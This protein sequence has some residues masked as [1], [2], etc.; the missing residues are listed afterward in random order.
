MPAERVNSARPFYHAGVDFCGPIKTHYKVRGKTPTKSY[1]AIF[2]CFS[3]KAIHI[4]VVGDLSSQSFIYALKRF[5]GKR[6]LCHTIF[7]DN[8]TNF[9]GAKNEL[10]ELAKIFNSSRIQAAIHTYC[11]EE[12]ITWKNI[13]PRSP[14][15]GGLWEATVKS[16]KMLLV[17]HLGEASLTYEELLTVVIQIEAILNSRP[18][19]PIS[20]DP[21]DLE[22]LTPGHF[23]IGSPLTAMA[24]PDVTHCKLSSLN[25][26]RRIQHIQ[27]HFWKRWSDEYLHLLQQRFK[28]KPESNNLKPDTLVLIKEENIP[29]MR[30]KLGRMIEIFKGSDDKVRVANVKTQTGTYKRAIHNLCPLPIDEPENKKENTDCSSVDPTRTTRCLRPRKGQKVALLSVL[31]L[32]LIMIPISLCQTLG[33]QQ[34]NVKKLDHG[35]GMYF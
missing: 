3:T 19:T 12:G 23:F 7:S 11:L 27:Q 21:N 24:E 8:A 15:F 29:P 33:E 10:A 25:K 26:F 13:P 14:H 28:W 5:I 22:A 18:L 30:W 6:G 17:R 35:V 31:L 4:E 32:A 2:V 9:V 16:A 20:S 1:L 34:V